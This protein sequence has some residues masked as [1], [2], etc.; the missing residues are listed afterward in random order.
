MNV[1]DFD[2]TIYRGDSTLDF[3]VYCLK[4]H[5]ALLKYLPRQGIAAIGFLMGRYDKTA[6]KARFFCFLKG[7]KNPEEEV[8]CFWKAHFCFLQDWYLRGKNTTDVIISASPGFLLK[9]VGDYL[10]VTIIASEVDIK[11]GVFRSPN[12]YGKEKVKRFQEN[13]PNSEPDR[14]YSDSKSDRPLAVLAKE[15]FLVTKQDVCVWPTQDQ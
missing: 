5:P 3:Y 11:T 12:C 1:Y 8:H 10:K 7:L 13:F 6:F 4:R 15:A 14:F 9:P 2:K